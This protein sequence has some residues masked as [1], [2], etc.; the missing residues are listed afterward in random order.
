MM[1]QTPAIDRRQSLDAIPV[2][3]T[4]CP[5]LPGTSPDREPHFPA[6]MDAIRAVAAERRLPLVDHTR[7]WEETKDKHYFWMNNAFH[8]NGY[9][10]R[11]FAMPLL[12]ALGIFDPQSFTGR[13]LIP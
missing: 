9:G 4:T 5:I 6:Y 2:L 8:P 1:P 7:Y 10:H 13:L 12:R 11:A 3:Q